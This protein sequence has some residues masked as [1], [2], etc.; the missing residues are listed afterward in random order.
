[1]SKSKKK[2]RTS[3]FAI[4]VAVAMS[5]MT[6][7]AAQ[8]ATVVWVDGNIPAAWNWS[9]THVSNYAGATTEAYT[10]AKLMNSYN[11]VVSSAPSVVTQS[12]PVTT[13][14]A[15]A[16]GWTSSAPGST[17]YMTCSRNTG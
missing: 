15:W 16:C 1:M 3:V 10:T 4:A 12:L 17:K 13:M 14:V 7:A 6:P 8:A 5:L 9:G 11:Y 2:L